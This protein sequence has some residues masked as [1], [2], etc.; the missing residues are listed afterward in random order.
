MSPAPGQGLSLPKSARLLKRRDYLRLKGARHASKTG[1]GDF[2]VVCAPNGLNRNRLGVTATRRSGCAV[3]RNRLKR[4][5]REFFR[6]RQ[7]SW[8]QGLD[9]LFIAGHAPRKAP[10]LHAFA[11]G[12]AERRLVKALRRSLSLSLA[13]R[14]LRDQEPKNFRQGRKTPGQ[15]RKAPEQSRDTSEQGRKTPGQGPKAP[16]LGRE[17]PEQ[18]HKATGQDHKGSGQANAASGPKDS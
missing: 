13:D 5:A 10:S 14:R 7:A 18:G 8:P 4:E 1:L 16:G 3:A 2:L 12:E 9:I 15:G 6:L 11:G 17:A